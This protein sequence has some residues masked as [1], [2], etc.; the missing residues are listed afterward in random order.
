[1]LAIFGKSLPDSFLPQVDTI[2][3]LL[4]KS[5]TP[6]CCF[7]TLHDKLLTKGIEM[8]CQTYS[9]SEDLPSDTILIL[10]LGGDGTML[11]T[12]TIVK[13]R[14]IPI[15]G[16]NTG[17]LGFLSEIFPHE[18]S[19]SIDNLLKGNYIIQP[20]TLIEVLSDDIYIPTYNFALNDFTLRKN[21]QSTL[22]QISVSVDGYFLNTYWADGL[23]ISTATGSTAYSMSVG[24]PILVPESKNLILSP[25]AS[26]NLTVRPLVIE[27]N[28]LIEIFIEG[29]NNLHVATLDN[30]NIQVPTRTKFKV[31][32]AD[33][34]LDIAQ[35]PDHHFFH[36]LRNKLM[37]G[38]DKRN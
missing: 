36:T 29:R 6:F 2:S 11:E 32:A 17:K 20:R 18:I 7:K 19:K 38:I 35:L 5:G 27:K 15:V 24:G 14:Q 31:R 25:I 9:S 1:M 10:C 8:H 22:V 23:I 3:A 26:H 34:T 30:R 12:L 33:F 16:V 21:D 37:W 28:S 4:K 13:E